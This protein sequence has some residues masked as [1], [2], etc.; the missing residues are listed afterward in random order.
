[1]S[2]LF[3]NY[4]I[5]LLLKHSGLDAL[6][7]DETTVF[8]LIEYGDNID[9]FLIS[10]YRNVNSFTGIATNPVRF[11]VLPL[12][13]ACVYERRT[14]RTK[15]TASAHSGEDHSAIAILFGSIVTGPALFRPDAACFTYRE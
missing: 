3:H 1:M 6:G 2:G 9:R 11:S 8:Y 4:D 12:F 14:K 13:Y 10:K 7:V 15:P 5:E